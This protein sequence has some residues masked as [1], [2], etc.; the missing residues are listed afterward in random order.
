MPA[1]CFNL[2]LHDRCRF[3]PVADGHDG[4]FHPHAM[5]KN[6]EGGMIVLYDRM[7]KGAR[8]LRPAGAI[9]YC[10]CGRSAL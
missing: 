6:G 1:H 5:R 3:E 7:E 9:P 10:G 8:K 2:D 4:R